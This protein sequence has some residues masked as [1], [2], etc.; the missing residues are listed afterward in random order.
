MAIARGNNSSGTGGSGTTC[1][2]AHTVAAGSDRI[3]FVHAM[4]YTGA[5]AVTITGITYGGV[6]MNII[7]QNSAQGNNRAALAYLINPTVGAANIVVSF[8]RTVNGAAVTAADYTGV[9][10]TGQPDSSNSA[11]SSPVTSRTLATT[12]VADNCWVIGGSLA[13]SQPVASTG[14]N[15]ITSSGTALLLGD[16]NGVKTPPGSYSMTVTHANDSDSFIMASFAPAAVAA[17]G[18][19]FLSIL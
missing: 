4:G 14:F 8:S 3:L 17:T 1:T 12:T 7:A 10:Q 5:P 2:V 11:A 13:G 15:T 16:S 6:A 9:A 18:A 19:N